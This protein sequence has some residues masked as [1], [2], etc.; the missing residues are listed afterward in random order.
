MAHFTHSQLQLTNNAEATNKRDNHIVMNN[1]WLA[2]ASAATMMKL[3]K[4]QK[5]ELWTR[6]EKETHIHLLTRECQKG[7]NVNSNRKRQIKKY[8]TLWIIKICFCACVYR[9]RNGFS[10]WNKQHESQQTTNKNVEILLFSCSF[11]VC[12]WMG[13]MVSSTARQYRNHN[14]TRKNEIRNRILSWIPVVFALVHLLMRVHR[15]YS[16]LDL[17]DTS[18]RAKC[19]RTSYSNFSN[20]DAN[21]KK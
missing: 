1:L 16:S 17:L 19:F 5:I 11:S 8:F 14:H 7:W 4:R 21:R 18:N 15:V 9:F 3:E 2:S 10:Q 20:S 12:L 13:C 6:E